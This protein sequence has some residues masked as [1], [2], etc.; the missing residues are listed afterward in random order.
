[1]RGKINLNNP[2]ALY[3]FIRNEKGQA[4]QMLIIQDGRVVAAKKI[5]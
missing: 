4:P 3:L 1:L 5:K 2:P